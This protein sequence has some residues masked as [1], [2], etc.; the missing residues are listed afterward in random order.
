MPWRENKPDPDDKLNELGE[1]IRSQ[2]TEFRSAL[3]KHFFWTDSSNASAGEPRLSDGSA[4]AG[5]A[6]A[7]FAAESAVSADRD[8]KLFLASD[9]T[10]LFGLTSGESFLLGSQRAIFATARSNGTRMTSNVPPGHGWRRQ[11][12]P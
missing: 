7:H 8:G 9:T 1:V 11:S 10:R 2:K 12:N 3:E 6:R 4:N 5:T